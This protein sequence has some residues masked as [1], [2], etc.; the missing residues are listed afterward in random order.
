MRNN[1]AY[2]PVAAFLA[3]VFALFNIGLPVVLDSCP[4]PKSPGSMTCALCHQALP[5]GGT[6]VVQS[7]RCCAP[8][9]AA[10]RNMTAFVQSQRLS[11]EFRA[12]ALAI[13]APSPSEVLVTAL[14]HV[15]TFNPSWSPPG[16]DADLPVLHSSLLI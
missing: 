15:Q 5:Q 16:R 9:I 6:P 7:P 8:V 12:V 13:L 10:E 4:M 1:S 2:R 3:I 14:P 11:E